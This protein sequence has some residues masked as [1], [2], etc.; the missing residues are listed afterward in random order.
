MAQSGNTGFEVRTSTTGKRFPEK[1]RVTDQR[2]SDLWLR[3][4]QKDADQYLYS[5][6]DMRPEECMYFS[7]RPVVE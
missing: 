3:T 2:S 1:D 6:E 4:R 7:T 5:A